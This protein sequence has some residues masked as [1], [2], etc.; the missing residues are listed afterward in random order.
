M[1]GYYSHFKSKTIYRGILVPVPPGLV[2]GVV[3]LPGTVD[4]GTVVL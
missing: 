3:V 1:P 4:D 2:L